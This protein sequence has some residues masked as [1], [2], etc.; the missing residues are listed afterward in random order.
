LARKPDRRSFGGGSRDIQGGNRVRLVAF[1]ALRRVSAE[2][3]YANL[4]VADVLRE[5]G[6]TGKDAAAVTD[7]VS[8]ACRWQGTLDR[9]IAAAA[10]RELSTLQPAVVDVL[11]LGAVLWAESTPAHAVV[12]EMVTLARN[13]IGERVSGL[14][15]AVMRRVVGKP[16]PE[17]LAELSAGMDMLDALSVRHAHPRWIV[18]VFAE[19][20]PANE[21]EAALNADNIPPVPTLVARPGLIARD[22]LLA[23]G[24]GAPTAYSPYGVT[25]P[26]NP[27][28][29]SP[30]RIGWAGVQDEGSQLVTLA[31][32]RAAT[33]YPVSGPW[34]DMC[35]GPGGKAALLSGLA[36]EQGRTLLANEL[37]P[38][39]A[40]LVAQALRGYP[41]GTHLVV[42]A[43]ARTAPWRESSFALTVADAPCS[44]LGALRRRPD[45]RW[46]R[47]PKS[48]SELS[49]LQRDLME[50]AVRATAPGGVVAWITCSPHPDETAAIV[51]HAAA[52]HGLTLLDAPSFL[53]EVP[54]AAA[55][56]DSRFV[57]LWPHRHGTDAMFLA[58]AVKPH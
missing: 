8:A 48:I 2:A 58:L 56:S 22:A 50:S 34:L 52:I 47:E 27:A 10:G 36:A 49:E 46:R 33:A 3:G 21:L 29:L 38:H 16:I 20:L 39:R 41:G 53:P 54:D 23:A 35:A 6:L 18:A 42:T 28:E 9:I 40:R 37:Q 17:W 45:S 57:Q 31:A 12:S 13:A 15:N 25:R 26:G 19:L 30:V 11:R 7:M 24:G 4:V 43:D 5:T 55:A 32:V 14:V 44:G 51:N 1:R